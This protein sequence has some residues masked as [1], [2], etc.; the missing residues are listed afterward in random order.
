MSAPR[1]WHR[2]SSASLRSRFLVA[3]LIW[4]ALG[5]GGIWYSATSVFTRHIEQQYHD[6]LY[7][8]VRELAGLVSV[9]RD[10]HLSLTRPL[11]APR[12]LEP[13]SGFYWQVSVYHGDVIRSASMRHG[14]LDEDI[15]HSPQI[16]HD[17][18][19][20]PTGPTIAYGFT[21]MTPDNR[22]IH[23]VI[24][25]DKRYLDAAIHGFTRELTLWLIALALALIGTGM[26]VIAFALR[27]LNRL[28]MAV[29]E[30]RGGRREPLQGQF[31]TEI[32]PLVD[33]LNI[34]IVENQAIIERARVQAGNLAHS[35]RTPLAII[36][37]EAERLSKEPHGKVH[38]ASLLRQCDIMV[39]QIDYHLARARSAAMAKTSG[40]TSPLPDIFTPLLGAMRKLHHDK[41]FDLKAPAG[42]DLKVAVDPMDLSELLSILLDNAGKWAKSRITISLDENDDTV[43]IRLADDG[44]GMTPQQ[45]V[46]A[47]A[48]GTRFDSAKPGSG[49]GLAIARDIADVYGIDLA[50]E[51]S[52][53]GGITA[54]LEIQA[55]PR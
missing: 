2:L 17:I 20:G 30:L 38:G 29:A 13:M 37:D 21:R 8:H 33:D 51:A 27:P 42:M 53:M 9:T 10:G 14:A 48:I 28:G 34:Y 50:L 40:R 18:E 35:L 44:P 15:A 43:A 5:I 23:Y 26:L 39:Q 41:M 25:T 11:S 31:P 24:A 19:R 46:D 45:M 7:G 47:F 6:E 52:P 22:N 36:T 3:I 49:L 54:R 12:Y 4:V 16:F 55:T 1:F 32:A